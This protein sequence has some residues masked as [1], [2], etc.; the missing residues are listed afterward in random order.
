MDRGRVG[1]GKAGPAVFV[2][3]ILLRERKSLSI[4]GGLDTD[5]RAAVAFDPRDECL[6]PVDHG[7]APEGGTGKEGDAVADGER[8]FRSVPPI[9]SPL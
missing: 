9:A 2:G 4:G 7:L 6:R 8:K 1:V 3:D 5:P